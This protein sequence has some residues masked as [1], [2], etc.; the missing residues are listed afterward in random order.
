MERSSQ[1]T[2]ERMK[3]VYDVRRSLNFKPGQRERLIVIR[4]NL[5]RGF[6]SHR[7]GPDSKRTYA[8]TSFRIFSPYTIWP[9]SPKL[10][11]YS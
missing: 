6:D 10:D 1:N 9:V 8:A 5:A 7:P 11:G 3:R 4:P 2:S